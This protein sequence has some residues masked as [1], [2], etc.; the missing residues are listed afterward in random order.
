MAANYVA[1]HGGERIG[2]GPTAILHG[3]QFPATIHYDAS[4]PSLAMVQLAPEPAQMQMQM[5]SSS[6]QQQL[7]QQLPQQRHRWQPQQHQQQL[8]QSF[9]EKNQQYLAQEAHDPLQAEYIATDPSAA[10]SM[11][12]N[13]PGLNSNDY[14]FNGDAAD[15]NNAMLLDL[16]ANDLASSVPAGLTADMILC[17]PSPNHHPPDLSK[18]QRISEQYMRTG[19]APYIA[20]AALF[21]GGWDGLEGWR[22]PVSSQVSHPSLLHQPY[23]LP[24]AHT[25]NQSFGLPDRS[26]LASLSSPVTFGTMVQQQQGGDG[27]LVHNTYG[28][29]QE[30]QNVQPAMPQQQ[31]AP[32]H[33]QHQAQIPMLVKQLQQQRSVP[34]HRARQQYSPPQQLQQQPK[35]PEN[36]FEYSKIRWSDVQASI[37]DT[38]PAGTGH[39]QATEYISDTG[40]LLSNQLTPVSAAE[41]PVI[42]PTWRGSPVYNGHNVDRA[43]SENHSPITP[44]RASHPNYR[45]ASVSVPTSMPPAQNP[46]SPAFVGHRIDA[47]V[48]ETTNGPTST[49]LQA[50]HSIHQPSV[51]VSGQQNIPSQTINEQSTTS[52]PRGGMPSRNGLKP[53]AIAKVADKYRSAKEKSPTKRKDTQASVLGGPAKK[54]KEEIQAQ[55]AAVK[56][57]KARVKAEKQKLQRQQTEQK[58]R[59]QVMK[60]AREEQVMKEIRKKLALEEQEK[61]RASSVTDQVRAEESDTDKKRKIELNNGG[62]QHQNIATFPSAMPAEVSLYP[63]TQAEVLYAQRELLKDAL[64]PQAPQAPQQTA[65]TTPQFKPRTIPENARN[66]VQSG[67]SLDV[68]ATAQTQ[69]PPSA[70]PFVYHVR[71]PASTSHASSTSVTSVAGADKSTPA[72][73]LTSRKEPILNSSKSDASTLEDNDENVTGQ[74]TPARMQPKTLASTVKKMG[75]SAVAPPSIRAESNSRV[76]S[77]T[78]PRASPQTA[79]P[80]AEFQFSSPPEATSTPVNH[81]ANIVAPNPIIFAGRTDVPLQQFSQQSMPAD[82]P[83]HRQTKRTFMSM[84]DIDSVNEQKDGNDLMGLDLDYIFGT[85]AGVGLSGAHNPDSTFQDAQHPLTVGTSSY[86]IGNGVTA[87]EDKVLGNVLG[88]V[89]EWSRSLKWD[90]DEE[91]MRLGGPSSIS[92]G[93][94]RS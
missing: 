92:G 2:P 44:G 50:S 87:D 12:S 43:V 63:D 86:G 72:F 94:S 62:N 28:G 52:A 32:P 75:K 57:E 33:F 66:E 26:Q 64:R 71:P 8:P 88:K 79:Q 17:P 73:N 15:I 11:F 24:A 14:N 58:K 21:A 84:D 45:A 93:E 81:R 16:L 9:L 48:V 55:K 25:H 49:A 13:V 29:P 35:L 77:Q 38:P 27:G 51:P 69:T 61:E 6:Q 34:Q 30:P 42:A 60:R 10:Q 68:V 20:S 74:K 82:A 37:L 40:D 1:T 65:V 85:D 89:E 3:Q 59:E 78:F 19:D 18:V 5:Q 83:D 91:A 56:E 7:R 39:R 90:I 41:S 46:I 54:T 31:Q 22:E 70:S 36:S 67:A 53:S 80:S 76:N 23:H 4:Q 47:Q